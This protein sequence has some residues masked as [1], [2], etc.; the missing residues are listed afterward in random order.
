MELSCPTSR[1]SSRPTTGGGPL[2]L[3]RLRP[4][5]PHRSA[6]DSSK[7][8]S[9]QRGSALPLAQR[10]A[11]CG[12]WGGTLTGRRADGVG[13]RVGRAGVGAGLRLTGSAAGQAPSWAIVAPDYASVDADRDNGGCRLRSTRGTQQRE[14]GLYD[15]MIRCL[16]L[17]E[18]RQCE[19]FI[20]HR[21]VIQPND[22]PLLVGSSPAANESVGG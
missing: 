13:H 16:V 5:L 3:Q 11:E 14:G 20:E 4:D 21:S 18:P 9:P 19:P 6:A 10:L 17:M 1:A 22:R 15:G 8:D 2:R 12:R 7:R